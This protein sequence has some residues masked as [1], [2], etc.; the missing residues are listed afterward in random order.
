M[1]SLIK[2]SIK[3]NFQNSG[4]II[5]CV[6]L[7]MANYYC[8]NYFIF[9]CTYWSRDGSDSCVVIQLIIMK[10]KIVTFHTRIIYNFPLDY[11]IKQQHRF[12]TK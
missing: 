6:E 5:F 2:Q 4:N 3:L 11:K 7:T 12:G 9:T 8:Y 1:Y 10:I